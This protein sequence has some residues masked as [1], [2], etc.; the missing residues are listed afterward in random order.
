M[1]LASALDIIE[2]G[3][4]PRAI[5]VDYPLGHTTG[6]PFDTEDQL[7][8]VRDALSGFET[9]TA[10]GQLRRLANDWGADDAWRREAGST[11]G[12]DTR[13]PRD[14]TPQFQHEADRAAAVAAGALS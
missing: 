7:N 3:R 8:I 10:A 9:M 13:Q 1:C 12:S 4:P 5:F 14:E 11:T 2:A 6:K